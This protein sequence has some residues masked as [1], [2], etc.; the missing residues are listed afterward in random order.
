MTLI[1]AGPVRL[2]SSMRGVCGDRREIRGV[3]QA[4]SRRDRFP[5]VAELLESRW[6]SRAQGCPRSRAD[7]SS[8]RSARGRRRVAD[9]GSAPT[10]RSAASRCGCSSRSQGTQAAGDPERL[11]AAV[12]RRRR[13]LASATTAQRRCFINEPDGLRRWCSSAATPQEA[14]PFAAVSRRDFL[15]KRDSFA[16]SRLTGTHPPTCTILHRNA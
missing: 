6:L 1:A 7:E 5:G 13:Q 2:C 11:T 4:S 3:S 16:P 9:C 14:I 12:S 10:C 8:V 15:G